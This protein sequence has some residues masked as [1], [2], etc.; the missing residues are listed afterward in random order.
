MAVWGSVEQDT[1]KVR[2]S[3]TKEK[4][5]TNFEE[6]EPNAWWTFSLMSI[7]GVIWIDCTQFIINMICL[8]LN[9]AFFVLQT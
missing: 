8:D 7:M 5:M 4:I 2:E 3:G 6:I 9:Y 1:G